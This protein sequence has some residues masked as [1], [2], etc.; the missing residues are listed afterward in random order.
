MWY[1]SDFMFRS[2]ILILGDN[3][4]YLRCNFVLI[5]GYQSGRMFVIEVVHI[6]LKG[7]EYAVMV[8]CTIK[9]IN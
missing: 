6:V 2:I 3:K 4:Y 8:L 5:I 1:M 7:L 9:K